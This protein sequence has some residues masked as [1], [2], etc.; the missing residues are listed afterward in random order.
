[1]AQGESP[2]PGPLV[3]T[4]EIPA[5]TAAVAVGTPPPKEAHLRRHVLNGSAIMLVSSAFVG[6][7]NLIYNFLVAHWL[8]ADQFGHA[9][10]VYTLLMLLSSIT[11]TFQL[12]CSKFVARSQSAAE[13]IAIYH[14]LHRWAW[15]AGVF[16]GSLLALCSGVITGYLNLP[17]K[18]LILLLALAAMFYV[19]LGVRRGFMQG[20]Y[21]F[22]P[23]AL[24]FSLEV[25]IKL[26]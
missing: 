25:I 9:S 22:R 17:S 19:P 20:T 26:V 3:M 13:K 10:V 1:M 5:E 12:V 7:M 11:L 15:A 18:T 14:L 24:N 8:G 21:D 23:L 16:V 2:S 4:D 6:G